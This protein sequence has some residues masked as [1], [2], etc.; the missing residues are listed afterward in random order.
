MFMRIKEGSLLLAALM[1]LSLLSGCGGEDK[2]TDKKAVAVK[3]M[4]IKAQSTPNFTGELPGRIASV[5]EVHIKSRVS[6]AVVE[7]YVQGGDWVEAGQPLY[8]IDSRQYESMVASSEAEVQRYQS[9]LANAEVDLAR[10]A[11][12]LKDKVIS[13]QTY[14][15]QET[16]VKTYEESV[17]ANQ[18]ILESRRVNLEDTLVCAPMSGK[19]SLDDVSVGTYAVEGSTVLASIS[20]PDPIYMKFNVTQDLYLLLTN[21]VVKQSGTLES[22][23]SLILNDG[24][25]YP[26]KGHITQAD[27]TMRDG[28]WTVKA[29]FPNPDALLVPGMYAR[30]TLTGSGKPNALLVPKAAV[31][32]LLGEKFVIVVNENGESS[33]RKIEAEYDDYEFGDYYL[34]KSG[35]NDGETIVVEGLSNLQGGIPLDVTLV[36]PEEMGYSLV[37]SKK[38]A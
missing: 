31:Q 32:E 33:S 18:A 3:A 14:Q 29:E 25:K 26:F 37:K 4:Q 16:K 36:T 23:V 38:A 5:D 11:E 30:V 10:D 8:R 27:M 21:Y 24:E 12:L 6:G 34:L 35:L 19:L 15:N 28:A 9:L 17:A 20:N 2:A 1:L 7:K 22:E 13:I